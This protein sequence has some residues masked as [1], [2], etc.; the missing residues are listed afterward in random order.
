MNRDYDNIIEFENE[1]SGIDFKA[2]QYEKKMYA[3]LLKDIIAMANADIEGERL[4]IIGVKHKSNGNREIRPIKNE[5]FIDSANYQQLVRENV[6]PE[7]KIDYAPH[8][9]KKDLLGLL[10]IQECYDP[11][12]MLKKDYSTL[13]KGD[14]YIRKGSHQPRAL[15]ADLDKIYKKKEKRYNFANSVHLGFSGTDFR[16]EITLSPIKNIDLPSQRAAKKIRKIIEQKKEQQQKQPNHIEQLSQQLKEAASRSLFGATPYEDRSI[17]TLEKNLANVGETYC[18][19]DMYEILEVQSYRLN[20]DILNAANEYIQDATALIEI[21][22]N[23]SF[24]ISDHILEE[25]SDNSLLSKLQSV[26]NVI[27]NYPKVELI[28]KVIQITNDVG[29]VKHLL[30]SKLFD[31]DIRLA[32][33]KKPESGEIPITIKLYAKNIATPIERKLKILISEK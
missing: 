3:D 13:K 2:I 20:F 14:C 29:E 31:E 27:S 32:I 25:P 18:E 9:Y 23:D 15:R 33:L 30:K 5:E 4:I 7:L 1:N 28:G 24:Q 10:K 26:H 8:Y 21:K 19:D 12:Y 17:D 22:S 6:E 11:P 16:Q